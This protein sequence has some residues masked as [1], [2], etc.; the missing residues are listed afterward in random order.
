MLPDRVLLVNI[1]P[2][3]VLGIIRKKAHH[4]PRQFELYYLFFLFSLEHV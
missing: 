4:S 3:P 1:S 2:V